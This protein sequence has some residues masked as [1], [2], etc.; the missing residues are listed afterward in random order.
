[1]NRPTPAEF[2][3]GRKLNGLAPNEPLTEDRAALDFTRLYSD[4]LRYCHTS[5]SWFEWDGQLWRRDMTGVAFQYARELSRELAATENDG[6]RVNAG[7]TSFAANVERAAR[8]DQE[9]AVAG[10]NWDVD[11]FLLGT[12]AGTVDLKTGRLRPACPADGITKAAAVAPA[13][14]ADC[15]MWLSFLHSA[16]G[17]DVDVIRFVQQWV[18]YSLT[19]DTREHALVF[20]YGDGGTGKSTFLNTVAGILG[21]YHRK[22]PIETFTESNFDRHPADIAALLGS[23]LVTASETEQGRHWAQSRIKEL[24]GG[25]AVSA[26]FMRQDFFT[27]TP[28]FKLTIAGNYKPALRNIGEAERRRINIIPF[29]R[30]P[31]KPGHQ[32]EAKLRGERPAILRWMIEGCLDWQRNGL[33]RPES[34]KLATEAYFDDQDTFSEWLEDACDVTIGNDHLWEKSSML[35]EAWSAYALKSGVKSGSAVGFAEEMVRR[36]FTKKKTMHGARWEGLRLKLPPAQQ[37][38]FD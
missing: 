5:G 20:V 32:L 9:L 12:P 18:G 21:D 30:K 17:G 7:K 31:E 8:S 16:T 29:T 14:S 36:G 38:S 10:D 19:G 22:T 26:R 2:V 35:F 27:F 13:E 11:L 34:V 37:M 6:V 24:T 3:S 33:I 28:Q 15:P 25:E 1:M 23:R 4:R